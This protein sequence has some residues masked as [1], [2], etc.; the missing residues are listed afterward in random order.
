MLN[1][2]KKLILKLNKLYYKRLQYMRN[3]MLNYSG[4]LY[5]ISSS[6]NSYENSLNSYLIRCTF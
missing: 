4:F 2:N 3:V 6:V 1:V 5:D